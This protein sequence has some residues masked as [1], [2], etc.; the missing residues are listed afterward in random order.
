MNVCMH[1]CMHRANMSVLAA[2]ASGLS[3]QYFFLH[4]KNWGRPISSSSF[5]ETT[6]K[7]LILEV[8]NCRTPHNCTGFMHRIDSN[9]ILDRL[10]LKTNYH[11]SSIFELGRW[12]FH[13]CPFVPLGSSISCHINTTYIYII[14]IYMLYSI[15]S[16]SL[17]KPPQA[18]PCQCC[19]G[20]SAVS[21]CEI[22][23]CGDN[24]DN[25]LSRPPAV[26]NV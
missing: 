1:A 6:K 17:P 9:Q 18:G 19:Q 10:A 16:D 8:A 7:T 4:P 5:F 23:S 12:S 13:K 21:S 11:W 15:P 24:A 14:F 3:K 22:S 20:A 2:P 26:V 25:D